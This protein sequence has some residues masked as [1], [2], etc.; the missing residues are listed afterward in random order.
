MP[1]PD[2]ITVTVLDTQTGETAVSADWSYFWWEEGNG[3][4]D[5]NREILFDRP[6]DGDQNCLGCTRYLIIATSEGSLADLNLDY[7]P[8]LVA[9]YCGGVDATSD[10]G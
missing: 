7:P 3:S 8:E 9:K 4:C 2:A 6:F 10:H 1:I 5:C